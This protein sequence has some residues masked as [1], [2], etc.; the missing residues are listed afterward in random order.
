MSA[1]S[2]LVAEITSGEFGDAIEIHCNKSDPVFQKIAARWSDI[3]RKTPRCIVLP[4]TEQEVAKIVEFAAKFK[5]P[6][7]SKAGGHSLWSTIG[8]EGFIL[9]LSRFSHIGID[10]ERGNQ[11]SVGAGVTIKEA[12]DAAFQKELLLPLGTSNSVGVVPFS[13]GG[14]QSYFENHCGFAADNIVSARVVTANGKLVTASPTSNPD[15]LWAIRGAGQ[16]FRVVTELTLQAYPISI[17]GN[18][19]GNVWKSSVVYAKEKTSQVLDALEPII[20]NT[21][22]M[23]RGM[24]YAVAPAPS[25]RPFSLLYT[26]RSEVVSVK[27]LNNGSAAL[28]TKGGFKPFA[29]T[30]FQTFKPAPFMALVRSFEE[31]QIVCPDARSSAYALAWNTYRPPNDPKG[32]APYIAYSHHNINIWAQL[33]SSYGDPQSHDGVS[34]IEQAALEDIRQA[35]GQEESEIAAYPNFTR[36]GPISRIYRGEERLCKLERLKKKWDPEGVFTRIFL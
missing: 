21:S 27:D 33:L 36:D 17:L 22:A 8:D 3:G 18:D 26:V 30:G 7:V 23:A 11:V 34:R 2:N 29:S 5:I 32:N 4:Q 1:V 19:R 10:I 15:L 16:L 24:F 20:K 12:N 14:G 6:F 28:D 9:D 31:L 35:Y 13:I 25:Y